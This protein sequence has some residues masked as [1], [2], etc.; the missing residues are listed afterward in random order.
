MTNINGK[1][2]PK[3]IEVGTRVKVG[4]SVTKNELA[5][6]FKKGFEVKFKAKVER[7]LSVVI[8]NET[9]KQI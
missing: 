6:N 3:R 5:E 4:F 8:S 7:R 9:W 1:S 2:E